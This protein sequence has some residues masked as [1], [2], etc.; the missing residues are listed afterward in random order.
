LQEV[1]CD[2]LSVR[3]DYPVDIGFLV[4]FEVFAAVT[5]KRTAFS[6]AT[7]CYIPEG[8]PFFV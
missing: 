8:F 6:L 5:M 3:S 2:I 7:W 1:L 4:G